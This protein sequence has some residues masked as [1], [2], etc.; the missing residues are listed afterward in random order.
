VQSWLEIMSKDQNER[1][2][3]MS[4]LYDRHLYKGPSPTS[5]GKSPVEGRRRQGGGGG[6]AAGHAEHRP[7]RQDRPERPDRPERSERPPR[8]RRDKRGGGAEAREAHHPIVT[9]K[10]PAGGGAKESAPK[11]PARERDPGLPKDLTFKPFNAIAPSVPED[12][13][14]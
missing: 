14:A 11:E 10:E 5:R 6:G 8:R 1:W 9:T 4:R 7:E 3:E 12:P 2:T 13:K